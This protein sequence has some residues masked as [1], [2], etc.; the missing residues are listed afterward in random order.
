MCV[1]ELEDEVGWQWLSGQGPRHRGDSDWLGY[2]A[3]ALPSIF[4]CL[5]LPRLGWGRQLPGHPTHPAGW[6]TCSSPCL[7]LAC[8]L[9]GQLGGHSAQTHGPSLLVCACHS[10]DWVAS[11]LVHPA[12]WIACLPPTS[13]V[14]LPP[15]VTWMADPAAMVLGPTCTVWAA[16]P[17]GAPTDGVPRGILQLL[18]GTAS[19]CALAASQGVCGWARPAGARLSLGQPDL[20]HRP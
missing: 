17:Q 9:E 11:W 6:I 8:P 18:L 12:G 13:P 14:P 1:A 16:E 3:A 19:P 5:H 7:C 15:P 4:A 20:A 10:W 2:L